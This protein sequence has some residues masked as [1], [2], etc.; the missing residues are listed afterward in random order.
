VTDV[1]L[2]GRLAD[3]QAGCDLGVAVAP[4]EALPVLPAR[5]LHTVPLQKINYDL[6]ETI[7]WPRL[8]A[9]VAREYRALPPSQR[10]AT[11]V[12]AGN[13]GEAGAL[14]RFGPAAGLPTAYSGANNFW[15]WGP[16]PAGDRS[17]IAISLSPAVLHRLFAT[18]RQVAVFRNG[19]GVADDEQGARIY[20]VSG[21]KSS[22]A[23]AWPALR[24]FS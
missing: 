5:I 24:D 10:A 11:T 12:L 1:R 4:R 15:Y 23:R 19:I 18:V 22:W 21:L 13:Y 2:H 14:G 7:G 3:H 8:V 9:L 6:G 16:P 17:A 20:L